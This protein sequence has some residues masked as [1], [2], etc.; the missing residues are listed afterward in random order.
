MALNDGAWE[1]TNI[2]YEINKGLAIFKRQAPPAPPAENRTVFSRMQAT[3]TV[4]E[5]VM[6]TNDL[7]AELPFLTLSGGGTIDL[8]SSEIDLKLFAMVRSDPELLADDLA[9]DIAGERIPLKITGTLD[10]PGIQPDFVV[11]LKE[12][13]KEKLLEKL[14]L[15]RLL[16]AKPDTPEDAADPKNPAGKLVEPEEQPK[17]PEEQLKDDVEEKIKNKLKDLFGGG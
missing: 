16:G 5:G 1:G 4:S 7:V 3:A 14:G 2:W 13:A 11:L 10:D 17:D 12:K 9:K 8:A 6:T 15:E